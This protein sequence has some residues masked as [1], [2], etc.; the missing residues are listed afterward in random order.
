PEEKRAEGFGILRVVANLSWIIGPTIGG[1]VFTRSP[2]VLFVAD[3]ITSLIMAAIILVRIPETMPE[4]SPEAKQESFGV[5]LLGYF[6]VLADKTFIAFMG[7]SILMLL[8]Y[9]QLY[10]TLSVYLRD[11][12]GLESNVY[13]SLM[14][15]NAFAVVLF[16]FWVTRKVSKRPPLLMMA[17]GAAL[18]MI[19]FTMYGFVAGYLMLLLAMIIITFGEMV[20]MPVSSAFVAKLAPEEMRGRYMAVFGLSW[21]IP[22]TF[23]PT[24][25]GIIIDNYDPNWVWYGG[26]IIAALSVAGFLL[27]H[28]M[29]RERLTA[30]EV[31]MA[32]DPEP[33][34]GD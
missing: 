34:M 6:K 1:L 7:A 5:T 27:L 16:Q 32:I 28:L 26:G 21:A 17:L 31:E 23:G 15:L 4:K 24:L 8:V 10:N 18:Y 3:A 2:L 20:V 12:H 22:A 11:V 13:G 9:L 25:A 30:G 33:A 29:T 19:G 14:S